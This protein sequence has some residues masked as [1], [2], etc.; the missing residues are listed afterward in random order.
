MF[1]ILFS[2]LPPDRLRKDVRRLLTLYDLNCFLVGRMNSIISNVACIRHRLSYHAH[3][4]RIE[5]RCPRKYRRA[6][7]MHETSHRLALVNACVVIVVGQE[8]NVVSLARKV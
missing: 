8:Y 2:K 6:L 4:L 7:P 1:K 5:C 3:G